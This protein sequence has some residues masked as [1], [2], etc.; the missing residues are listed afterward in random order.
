[1]LKTFMRIC[2]GHKFIST[3]TIC[4][5]FLLVFGKAGWSNEAPSRVLVLTAASASTVVQQIAT[6]FTAATG[7]DVRL[8]IA[9]SGTLARQV[10][11]DAPAG[12]YIS[13]SEHW[14]ERLK[15]QDKL[16]P[17]FVRPLMRNRLVVVAPSNSSLT[18]LLDLTKSVVLLTAI[19]NGR[20]AIGDPQH[21]PAGRYAREALINMG[22]WPAVRDR[23]APQANVRAVL[24]MVERGETPLGLTYATDAALT[25][26][27]KIAAILPPEAHTPIQYFAAIISGQKDAQTDA[28]FSALFTPE[29]KMILRDGGFG[30]S[31][32][33]L[34]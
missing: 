11:Q 32:N 8:S 31:E 26:N 29:A 12:I 10:S 34:L 2:L 27:V 21:V 33:D 20:L 30:V 4:V 7:I 18:G 6:D 19:G 15:A 9:S 3:A 17:G 28:F 23:L 16:E 22:L 25:Q 1:M 14:I 5:A 13:A 24:A